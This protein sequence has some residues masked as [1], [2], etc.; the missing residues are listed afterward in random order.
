MSLIGRP[1][2]PM[3]E[4]FWPKVQKG[5][6]CWLWIGGFC[7][8]YG[9]ISRGS[10]SLGCIGAHVAS[11]EINVGPTGGLWVLHKCDNPACVRPDHLMLGTALDN[12]RDMI[13]KGRAAD[14]RGERAPMV[15]LTEADVHAIRRRVRQGEK[16]CH[17]AIA[18]GVTQGAVSGIVNRKLWSHI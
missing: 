4:R 9:T 7:G 5:P 10:K 6:G 12:T 16:Q 2:R 15:K 13:A 3:A 14:R 11:Y 1:P 17:V 18:F 8:K